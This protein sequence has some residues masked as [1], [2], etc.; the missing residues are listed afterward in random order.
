MKDYQIYYCFFLFG[1]NL[2]RLD[3]MQYGPTNGMPFFFLQ[4]IQESKKCNKSEIF[5][6]TCSSSVIVKTY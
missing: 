4:T 1:P 3:G 5:V 6:I 2:Q